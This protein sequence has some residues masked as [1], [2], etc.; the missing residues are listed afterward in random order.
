MRRDGG[1]GVQP[2]KAYLETDYHR[3]V[4]PVETSRKGVFIKT[5]EFLD[6]KRFTINDN[7]V[8]SRT[9]KIPSL[10]NTFH[11]D[12]SFRPAVRKFRIETT[13]ELP[14]RIVRRDRQ[15]S[16]KI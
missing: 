13:D 6:R 11:A 14:V 9:L 3:W 2:E 4:A 15:G 7:L 5:Q 8:R 10:R 16:E 12:G 1:C